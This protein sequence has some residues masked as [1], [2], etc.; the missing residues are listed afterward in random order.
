[1]SDKTDKNFGL[2]CSFASLLVWATVTIMI[3]MKLPVKI[4][5]FIMLSWVTVPG[6][7]G[8]L[9]FYRLDKNNRWGH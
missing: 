9:I 1:M 6:V 4:D 8:G 2:Y 7:V 3:V 5:T